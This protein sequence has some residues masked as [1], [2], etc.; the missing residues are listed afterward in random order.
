MTTLPPLTAPP[1]RAVPLDIELP[2]GEA[3]AAVVDHYSERVRCDHPETTEGEA[4]GDALRDEAEAHDTGRV[5]VLAR[6]PLVAG[7]E[8]SGYFCE[9]VMPGF[10]RGEEDCNVMGLTLAPGGESPDDAAAVARVDAILDAKRGTTGAG[11]DHRTHRATIDDAASIASLLADTFAHYPTPSEDPAYIA[12]AIAAGVPFRTVLDRGRLVAC[13]SAD[14][15]REART[16]ELTDCATLPSHRGRGYM[17]ALLAD[18]MGDLE[19][20]GYPTAFT[21]ARAKEPGI[22]VAFQRLGFD[23]RGRMP[24]SCRIGSGLEDMNVWSRRLAA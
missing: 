13:A 16:A 9:A 11:A 15:V 17:R 6:D 3:V 22:N 2:S 12:E 1:P 7:L 24:R 20:M 4:L 8:A 23:L 18:L 21:L 5:V 14:L 19:D 10:Y